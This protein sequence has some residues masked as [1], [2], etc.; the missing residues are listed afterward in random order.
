MES[1]SRIVRP[2]SI[3]AKGL[4]AGAKEPAGL[5]ELVD[6]EKLEQVQ[7]QWEYQTD[8]PLDR[9]IGPHRPGRDQDSEEIAED[10]YGEKR[11]QP[12]PFDLDFVEAGGEKRQPSILVHEKR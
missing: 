7:D 4:R 12:A 1:L 3:G 10:R 2:R 11:T 9:D 5:A 8:H 6:R